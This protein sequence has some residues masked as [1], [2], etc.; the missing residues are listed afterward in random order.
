MYT[1]LCPK[2]SGKQYSTSDKKGNECCVYCGHR[3]TRLL[4]GNNKNI[5]VHKVIHQLKNLREH[6][7]NFARSELSDS[8]W[9]ADIEALDYAIETLKEKALQQGGCS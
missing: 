8:I 4:N 2:C 9:K 5:E 6:C 1:Y 7:E 3:G